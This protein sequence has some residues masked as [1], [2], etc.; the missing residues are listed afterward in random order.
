MKRNPPPPLL[1]NDKIGAEKFQY[2]LGS[3]LNKSKKTLHLIHHRLIND[4]L[5]FTFYWLGTLELVC[6]SV[7]LY[8]QPLTGVVETS[9]WKMCSSYWPEITLKKSWIFFFGGGQ[10]FLRLL[11]RTFF[12]QH[13]VD[14]EGVMAQ[15]NLFWV[16]LMWIIF[17]GIL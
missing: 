3:F 12:H 16:W 14:N 1:K 13:T 4:D 5:I 8:V 10:F 7:C 15:K 6:L 17:Y 2:F 11:K 9:G